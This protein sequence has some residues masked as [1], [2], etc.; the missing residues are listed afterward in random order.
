MADFAV[1]FDVDGVLIDSVAA[2]YRVRARLLAKRG[3]D[4]AQVP[5]PHHED[6]KGSSL[7]GLLAAVKQ[8]AG[9]TIDEASFGK[10]M[11]AGL[12]DELK[13][14]QPDPALIALLDEL[15]QHSIPCAVASSGRREGVLNKLDIL[16]ITDYFAA[17]VTADDVTKHKPDPEIYVL[18]AKRLRLDAQQCVVIEDSVAGAAAGRAAG[19]SVIGFTKYND[20]KGGLAEVN[21]TV[22]NWSQ[23]SYASLTHTAITATLR[24][25]GCVFAEEEAQLLIDEAKD[26]V[27][28]ADMVSRRVTGLPLEH[29]VGWAEFCGLHIAVGPGVFVPRHRTEFLV[30]QAAT[31]ARPGAVVVDLC[32]GSGAVGVA[33][34][35]AQK[36]IELHAAD[37][38]LVAVKYA[39]KNVATVGGQ[40]YEGDLYESLPK[41]LRGRID[42]LVVNAPYVPTDAIRLM[43]SEARLHEPRATLDGGQDGLDV[44]RRV[45]A[46]AAAWLAPGGH[47]LIE[48]SDDQAAIAAAL[49][50]SHGLISRIVSD[51]DSNGAVVIGTLS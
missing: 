46:E 3:V 1:I 16:G 7:K 23:L 17:I 48:T 12:Y 20:D 29:I 11:V 32:C 42:L 40:V 25:A 38:D 2:A 19:C 14:S 47:L 15:K 35:T 39:R 5:D 13:G 50:T 37:I 49:F 36:Q 8:H 31:L 26:P 45:A 21:L 22:D 27:E 6:H 33:L 30:E 44:H 41:E 18:A 24:A 9:V 28:L 4:M 43:P 34:K 10:E 51:E